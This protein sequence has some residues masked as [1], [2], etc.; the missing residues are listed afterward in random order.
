MSLS[1]C[2]NCNTKYTKVRIDQKY[3]KRLCSLQ[4]R[5][6]VHK[7][8]QYSIEWRLASLK[9]K[10]DKFDEDRI[11]KL[12]KKTKKEILANGYD[13]KINKKLNKVIGFDKWRK[14]EIGKN[15][16]KKYFKKDEVKEKIKKYNKKPE[17]K[18]KKNKQRRDFNLTEEGQKKSR[19]I[20]KKR[21]AKPGYRDKMNRIY[22]DRIKRDPAFKMRMSLSRYV[23]KTLKKQNVVKSMKF[24]TLLGC[25]VKE[26]KLYLE[27]KF[28]PGMS[29]EN[30]GLYGWHI[31]HI[32]PVSK[33]KLIDPEEQKKCFHYTT[34][35]PLWAKENIKKGNKY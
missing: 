8:P 7:N 27:K 32:K 10:L 14:S 22:N 29:W 23:V 2:L 15:T 18:E 4:H 35:Q 9:K 34:L 3:C 26:F 6:K 12:F 33:F 25:T 24:Q 20:Y 5:Y 31:D 13:P 11:K 28:K 17:V 21:K 30:H 16:L 19:L 1:I